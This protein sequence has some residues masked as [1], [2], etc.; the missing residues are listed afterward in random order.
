MDYDEIIREYHPFVS[1]LIPCFCEER[2]ID[3]TLQ[4]V[5]AIRYPYKEVVVVDD[6]SRD[7]TVDKVMPYVRQGKVRL[8]QK[9]QNEGKPMALNDVLP[10][11]RGEIILTLDADA[12]P[13]QDILHYIVPHFRFPRV[14][15]VTGNPRVKNRD[16]FLGK[17]QAVEFTSI[18]S[19]LRRAQ[20]I[21]GR[22]FTVSGVVVAWRKNALLDVGGWD[23]YIVTEDINVSWKLQKRAFDIRYE[24]QAIAWIQVP[25]SLRA[26]WRQRIRWAKGLTQVLRKHK[27]VLFTWRLRR[28]MPA[29]IES[30]L[31]VCW[32]YSFV[33]LTAFW[34][35]SFALGLNPFGASPIPA[36]WGVLI[37][38]MNL[39]QFMT[40]VVLDGQY[41]PDVKRFYLWAIFYPL[42]YWML[43]AIVTSVATPKGIFSNLSGGTLARWKTERFELAGKPAR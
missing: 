31:S 17:I 33:L 3:Q 18:V 5:L 13:E 19:L 1:I 24:P 38:T 41:E 29:Y 42:I 22:I 14:A 25:R 37:G 40:G 21:W 2:L 7:E 35:L 32:A 10:L 9:R 39:S 8:V 27:D 30:V 43:M 16:S 4:S 12:Q 20:R 36:W 34:V 23:P 26:L 28:L 11:L 6:G 15:A